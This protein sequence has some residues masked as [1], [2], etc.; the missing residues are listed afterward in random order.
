MAASSVLVLRNVDFNVNE[1]AFSDPKTNE[2]GGQA[3]YINLKRDGRLVKDTLIQSPWM[4]NPFGLTTS[5]VTNEGERLKYYVELSFGNAPSAYV[6]DFHN[7][8][9]AMDDKV[10]E[11]AKANGPAWG[12]GADV[13]DEYLSEFFKPSV[14]VYKNKEKVATGEYSDMLRFKVP[15]YQNED[16]SNSFGDLELYDANKQR[17]TFTTID[18]LKAALGRSN[19]VRVIG[20]A[21]SVWQS[22]KEFGVSWQVVRIQVLGNESIGTDCQVML[23]DDEGEGKNSDDE[24]Y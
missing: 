23:S 11:A 6:E 5:M 19:R 2:H 3:M 16:G 1:L 13:D 9:R 7:K 20:R 17:I 22:G 24:A 4:F 10:R 15:Y 8:M 12:L 18:E 21:H 14:R